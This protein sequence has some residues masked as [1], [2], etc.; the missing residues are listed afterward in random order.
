MDYNLALELVRC[1]EAAA[2][3]ASEWVGRGDPRAADQ[4]A[5]DGMRRTLPS[6][7]VRNAVE[8]RIVLGEGILDA[9]PRLEGGEVFGHGKQGVQIA[10][11]PLE[12]ADAAASGSPGVISVIAACLDGEGASSRF[13]RATC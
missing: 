2:L 11:D 8:G 12:G 1:T 5:V 3:T 4:A 13:P 9:A 10:V 7:L 6:V